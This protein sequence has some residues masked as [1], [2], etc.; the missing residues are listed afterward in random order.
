MRSALPVRG[1]N[2]R[3]LSILAL[4]TAT[5]CVGHHGA[6]PRVPRA[7]TGTVRALAAPPLAATGPAARAAHD[8]EDELGPEEIPEAAVIRAMD[9]VAREAKGPAR[10]AVPSPPW[11]HKSKPKYLDLV[12]ERYGMTAAEEAMLTKNGMVVLSRVTFPSYGYAMHEIHRQELPLYVTADSLLEAVFRSHE[13]VVVEAEQAVSSGLD[14]LLERM[15][16]ALIA[17]TKS[18]APRY[19]AEVATDADVYLGVARTLIGTSG[20]SGLGQ[21]AEIDPLVEKAQKAEAVETVDLFG[22]PR[23]IDFTFY[24]PRGVYLEHPELH[25][26]FRAMVWLTRLEMNVVSRG[27]RSSSP[28]L[29][30]EET[31]REAT[32]ALVLADLVERAGVTADVERISSYQ[33]KLGGR[34][35]DVP[36]SELSKVAKR[37]SISFLDSKVAAAMLRTEIGTSYP[38][39]VNQHVMPYG[40]SE[41]SLPA[42][43]TFFGTSITADARSIGTLVPSGSAPRIPRGPEL[44]YLFGADAGARYV[45]PTG[46]LALLKS[47]RADLE[48]SL[49]RGDSD[50]QSAWTTLVRGVAVAPTGARP[51]FFG[52]TAQ[53]DRRISTA[54]AGYAQ[55]HHAHVLHTAQVYDFSGCTIP[56]AYVEPTLAAYEGTLAYTK[57]L[58]ELVALLPAADDGSAN[59]VTDVPDRL[60]KVTA[61]LAAITRDELAGR[62]V[63]QRQL[64]FLRMVAEYIPESGG[65][66]GS[67]PGRFNGWYPYMHTARASAFKKVPF[68]IDHFT[69]TRLGAIAF[70]GEG[71]PA[72]GVFVVD[73]G[74]EPRVMVGPVTRAYDRVRP[75][76]KRKD[77]GEPGEVANVLDVPPIAG[78]EKSYVAPLVMPPDASISVQDHEVV[79]APSRTMRDV[80]VE[81][82]D[83]HGATLSTAFVKEAKPRKGNVEAARATFAPKQAG[84]SLDEARGFRFRLSTGEAYSVDSLGTWPESMH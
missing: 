16:K 48:T 13:D 76:G 29:T 70:V 31:P 73:V 78:Y 32:L 19:S 14:A 54:I 58:Q 84:R 26:Y 82:C 63:S 35:E 27:S 55:I 41:S 11:D 42:I 50:L 22:R 60:G 52:T 30:T 10:A 77:A 6:T 21:D 36:L 83:A 23:K 59:G 4:L 18:K 45:D 43:A 49:A 69:S 46:S 5:S 51:S 67:S 53:A 75:L 44:A 39:S 17:D 34:R 40:T 33:R 9:E 8:P 3:A 20:T 62:P 56:D 38:R 47:A 28:T 80:T 24:E 12:K 66:E 1:L 68:S 81:L 57:R 65:Y 37:K 79:I 15:Q 72:L 74:G 61:A 71:R 7:A 64:A 2:A 25:S